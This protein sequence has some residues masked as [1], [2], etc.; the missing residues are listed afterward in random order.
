MWRPLIPGAAARPANLSPAL[1]ASLKK[2]T[3]E[4]PEGLQPACGRQVR[5]PGPQSRRVGTKGW[6]TD[7]EK[8]EALK[9][10]NKPLPTQY[11]TQA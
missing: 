6:V 2:Q 5:Q 3:S 1:R 7:D 9:E 10:R 4:E 11:A 8:N